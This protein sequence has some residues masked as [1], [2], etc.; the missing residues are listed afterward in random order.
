[1][2]MAPGETPER[3][4]VLLQVAIVCYI[5]GI[6]CGFYFGSMFVGGRSRKILLDEVAFDVCNEIEVRTQ[7]EE[8]LRNVVDRYEHFDKN[9]PKYNFMNR[10][11]D[12]AAPPLSGE[13]W[14]QRFKGAVP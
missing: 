10:P 12:A 5:L 11:S 9:K 1:M 6:M 7:Y 4:T 8:C 14:E 3:D 13:E 2:S